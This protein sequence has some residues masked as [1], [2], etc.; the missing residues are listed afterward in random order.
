[1]YS[2]F[3]PDN[4]GIKEKGFFQQGR[5]IFGVDF[6]NFLGADMRSTRHREQLETDY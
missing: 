6:R 4:N 3:S 5:G 2:P 1:M